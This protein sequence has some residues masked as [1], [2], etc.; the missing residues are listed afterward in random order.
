MP[1]AS[2]SIKWRVE[3]EARLVK[4]QD[5]YVAKYGTSPVNQTAPAPAAQPVVADADKEA[6]AEALK[7]E[8]AV[9]YSCGS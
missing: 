1:L 6:E 7:A 4:A 3:Y 8:G 2:V 5:T 9:L